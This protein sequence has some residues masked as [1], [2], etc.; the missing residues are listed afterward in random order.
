MTGSEL[1][2]P[3]RPVASPA[4]AK[5]VG[6]RRSLRIASFTVETTGRRTVYLDINHWYALGEAMAGRPQK[7]E[8]VDVLNQLTG[9]VEQG[10]IMI[11]LSAVNYIELSENPRDHQREEAAK[12]MTLLARF[13]TLTSTKRIVDEELG[14]ALN[15]MFG[16]PAFP[17]R[18]EKFGFG[19]NFALTGEIKQFTLVGGTDDSR[20][21]LEATLGVSITELEARVNAVSEY[22][23]LKQPPRPYASTIPGYDPYAARR[24]ADRELASFNVMANALRTNPD[25]R[26]RPLDAIYARQFAVDIEAN[27]VQALLNAGYSM[28]RPPPLRDRESLT[29][30]LT[31]MPSRRVATMLQYHYLKDSNKHW[32]INDLRDNTALAMTIPYCDIVVTDSAAWNTAVN[33]AH[34][35]KEFE[36]AMFRNLTDL[37][38]HLN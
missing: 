33:H 36:T 13:N 3:A 31:S 30:L 26:S 20:G 16:R 17:T 22:E 7:P 8:H 1:T 14:L 34:L 4:A 21:R 28:D 35:D 32:K 25:L 29:T 2:R 27:F 19:A 10:R 23:L 37:A 24:E 6:A 9:L 11:P 15:R 38:A 18:T 5:P 12:V